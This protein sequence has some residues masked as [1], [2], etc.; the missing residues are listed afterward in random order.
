MQ[1][2]FVSSVHSHGS[3]SMFE[4]HTYIGTYVCTTWPCKRQHLQSVRVS[5]CQTWNV[6]LSKVWGLIGKVSWFLIVTELET[7]CIMRAG[8]FATSVTPPA[9][10]KPCLGYT[11]T[12]STLQHLIGH[13]TQTCT[14][15]YVAGKTHSDSNHSLY[16]YPIVVQFIRLTRVGAKYSEV[17]KIKYVV[18]CVHVPLRDLDF[19]S[20][21]Y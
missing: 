18:N 17:V 7:C 12:R 6:N 4:L 21:Q 10:L 20:A 16:P 19:S 13:E 14:L 8:T 3:T 9:H 11:P 15:P 5:L 1:D 2:V